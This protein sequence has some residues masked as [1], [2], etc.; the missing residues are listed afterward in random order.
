[1]LSHRTHRLTLLVIIIT[2]IFA[3]SASV[4]RRCPDGTLAEKGDHLSLCSKEFIN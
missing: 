3:L 1:M 2:I 4:E